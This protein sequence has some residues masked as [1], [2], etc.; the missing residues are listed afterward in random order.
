CAVFSTHELRRVRYKCTD[1]VLWKHA[2]PTK[3]WEKPLWLIPIH[4]IEEEHWVLAF[5]DVGHQQI[6]FFDSLG[7]QGHGWRQDIQ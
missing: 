6:L 4:R 2:H 3:F 5:V 7:V 1:D